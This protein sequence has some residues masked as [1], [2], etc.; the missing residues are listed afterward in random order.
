MQRLDIVEPES[1]PT[2]R[3]NPLM[4]V[5]KPNGKLRICLDPKHLN[6]VIKCQHY[7]LST[8]EEL[9]SGMYNANLGDS[10]GYCQIKADREPSKLLTF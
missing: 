3:V 4:I 8:E 6:Q 2:E 5:E 9:F 7:K 10:S 1:D